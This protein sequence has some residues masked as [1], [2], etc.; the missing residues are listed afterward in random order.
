MPKGG[1]YWSP[2]QI[3]LMMDWIAEGAQGMDPD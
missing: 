3:Q 1:P 2:E